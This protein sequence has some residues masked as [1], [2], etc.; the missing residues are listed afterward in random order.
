MPLLQV[1]DELAEELVLRAE[2]LLFGALAARP[3]LSPLDPMRGICEPYLGSGRLSFMVCDAL[4]TVEHA[5]MVE[6]FADPQS[7][8]DAIL[9]EAHRVP[10]AM[11]VDV[12]LDVH[13]TLVELVHLG[14]V[15][16]ERPQRWLLSHP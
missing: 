16:R 11:Q 6:R 5:D 14:D 13:A 4:P 3:R 2:I 1:V 15:G 8:A 12:P 9:V 7:A 10:I